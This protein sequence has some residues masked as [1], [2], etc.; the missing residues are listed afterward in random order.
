MVGIF[1]S[2]RSDLGAG[3]APVRYVEERRFSAA[4]SDPLPV[5]PTEADHRSP[6]IDAVEGPALLRSCHEHLTSLAFHV[7]T[8]A[9]PIDFES[10][11]GQ[12]KS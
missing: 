9:A 2:S 11:V 6:M 4:I 8:T 10:F 7:P 3:V 12:A 1:P 5:I